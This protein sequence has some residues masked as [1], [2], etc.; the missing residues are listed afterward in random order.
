MGFNVIQQIT[1]QSGGERKRNHQRGNDGRDVGNAQGSE[2]FTFYSLH[3]KQRQKY[4]YYDDS[5]INNRISDLRTG[6]INDL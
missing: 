6:M 1:A 3:I 2:D 4:Q 5:G